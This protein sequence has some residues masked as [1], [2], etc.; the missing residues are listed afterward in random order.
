[1]PDPEIDLDK[2][3]RAYEMLRWV[4]YSFPAEFNMEL[5]LL[6]VYSKA[7][8]ERS[9]E[10]I[11]EFEKN[12]PYE[13]SPELAAFYKLEKLGRFTQSDYYSPSKAQE[14]YYSRELKRFSR[15]RHSGARKRTQERLTS[16]KRPRRLSS[17]F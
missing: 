3:R 10:A 5:A 13:T 8:K 4:P 12:N 2:E 7:Q 9:D 11:A 17:N 14:G 16:N 1:M 15:N 6:G